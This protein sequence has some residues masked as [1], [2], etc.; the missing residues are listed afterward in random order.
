MKLIAASLFTHFR[1]FMKN[2]NNKIKNEVQLV[3]VITVII[4]VNSELH[5]TSK[6]CRIQKIFLKE[7]LYMLF[8]F[9][10]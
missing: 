8:L 9:V 6:A 3:I 5:P 1:F 7:F 10:L 4:F 2:N